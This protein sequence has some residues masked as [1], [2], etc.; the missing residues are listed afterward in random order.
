MIGRVHG[1]RTSASSLT[2]KYLFPCRLP[3]QCSASQSCVDPWDAQFCGWVRV[4]AYRYDTSYE[5]RVS[6]GVT[7]ILL[8][9]PRKWIAVVS[10]QAVVF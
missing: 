9:V 2:A 1:M 6:V 3:Y 7:S 5:S 4:T 10:A 8:S